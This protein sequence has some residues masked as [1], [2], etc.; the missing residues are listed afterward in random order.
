MSELPGMVVLAA[1]A[2][3]GCSSHSDCAT[4]GEFTFRFNSADD[5]G[6]AEA[7]DSIFGSTPGAVYVSHHEQQRDEREGAGR[8]PRAADCGGPRQ[9]LRARRAAR[10]R[11]GGALSP[12]DHS[13][14]GGRQAATRG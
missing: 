5:D 9:R 13:G 12:Q 11:R 10:C 6:L 4:E 3:A 7:V 8:G 1:A 14:R 2:R